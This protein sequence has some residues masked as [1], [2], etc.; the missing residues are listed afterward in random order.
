[1][2][3][4]TLPG[5][6]ALRAKLDYNPET[7]VLTW[8]ATRDRKLVGTQAKSLDVGGYVQVNTLGAVMK[9]HRVAW[10]IHYGEW[11]SDDIDHINGVRNDNRISNLRCVNGTINTQNKR[12][13][14]C[15]NRTGFLGVHENLRGSPEKRFRAK[16]MVGKNQIHLGGYPTPEQAH[17]AYV[18]AKRKLHAGC[19]I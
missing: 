19:A 17:E 16:I 1:M 2:A 8:K 11:P 15:K 14:S 18:V 9:G 10:A 13:G 7:G 12:L 4:Q 6:D 5:I 3:K